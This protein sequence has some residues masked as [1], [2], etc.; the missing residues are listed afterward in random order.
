MAIIIEYNGSYPCLCT[1][2]MSAII[3][4]IRYDFPAYCL[5]SGG[6]AWTN[7][8]FSGTTQGEW[9]ISKWTKSF[10]E[11]FKIPTIVAIN[12]QIEHGCCGGCI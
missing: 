9:S 1:G 3:A 5:S 11:E 8:D 6:R 2:K 10:P 7:D 12:E 4:G